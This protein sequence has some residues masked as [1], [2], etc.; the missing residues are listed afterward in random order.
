MITFEVRALCYECEDGRV[1]RCSGRLVGVSWAECYSW[2]RE[3][4]PCARV[5]EVEWVDD[6]L[7]WCDVKGKHV[8]VR[9]VCE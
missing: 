7:P 2:C 6:R 5:V 4:F 3:V 1:R 9:E 8:I